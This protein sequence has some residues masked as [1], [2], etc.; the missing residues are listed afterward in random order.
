MNVKSS[1]KAVKQENERASEDQNSVSVQKGMPSS[2]YR[3]SEHSFFKANSFDTKNLDSSL[4][5]SK[6]KES[7]QIQDVIT[8]IRIDEGTLEKEAPEQSEEIKTEI[9]D[10]PNSDIRYSSEN[11]RKL[12]EAIKSMEAEVIDI[13]EF[14]GLCLSLKFMSS[15]A[16]IEEINDWSYEN[17][18]EPLLDY[19]PEENCIYISTDLI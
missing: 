15:D 5:D 3:S 11:A 16:A 18:D 19:A 4:I 17:F 10:T 1:V 13:N 6:L 2:L 7:A 9:S 14:K 8:Q 12:I